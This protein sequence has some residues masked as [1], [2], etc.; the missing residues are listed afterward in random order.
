MHFSFPGRLS[1]G[2]IVLAMLAIAPGAQ[3]LEFRKYPALR[4]FT[5]EMTEKHGFSAKQLQRV[6]RCAAIRPDIIEAMERP[7]ELLPWH[8]YRKIFV[9]EDSA[10]RGAR[11]WQEHAEDISRAQERYGVLPEIIVAIIGVET[12]YGRNPGNHSILDALTTL[13]LEYPSRAAFFR[14]E[15]AEF[16]L[17]TRETDID[18]CRVKGSYAGAM[19]L[20]QFMPSNYRR[21]AVDF[22]GDGKRNLLDNPVDAIGSVAHYLHNNGWETGAPVIEAA[23]L[24][25][26]LY[27]WVEKLGLKPA[28][29]VRQLAGYGVFP[30][31]RENPERRAALISL[32]GED[33]PVYRLGYN[34][35]YA[36]TRY[37]LNK[38]Y[39]MAVVELG[40]L[41]RQRMEEN[42]SS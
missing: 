14:E 11:F 42:P 8:E 40:E 16:L 12:R 23:R 10:K 18:P 3:A 30:R 25:G 37:N 17:L 19:G 21:L 2:C 38:R 22:D 31:R 35:F 9:T 15:L 24:E 13:T 27:F 32:E 39:A 20:P 1:I 26:T 36:I 5:A 29:S 41:I 7:R 34:N 6:F 28:L 33:G 4:S